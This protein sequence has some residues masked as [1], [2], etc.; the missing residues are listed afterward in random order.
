MS[1]K[2]IAVLAACAAVVGLAAYWAVRPKKASVATGG[3]DVSRTAEA[4]PPD[5]LQQRVDE[6]VGR[7][8][9]TIVL[10]EDDD[11]QPD[12]EKE[13]TSL[14]GRIIFQENH[15]AISTLSDELT[16]AIQNGGDW[17]RAPANVA[18]FLDLVEG[19]ADLHDA[20]KLAFRE[21]FTDF[22]EA[23]AGVKTTAAAKI[24][25]E[26]RV[27]TDRQALSEIQAMYEKELDKIFGRFE[28]RGMVVRREAW[29]RYVAY[30]HTKFRRE[31]ILK[32]YESTVKR[33]RMSAKAGHQD[34]DLES[35]GDKLPPKTLLL[36]FDDGPH[37]RYTDR[38]LE[39]LRQHQ[40]KSV[41]FELGTN[42]ARV[43]Q[44]RIQPT[45]AAAAARHLVEAGYTVGSHGFSHQVLP[46][47][48]DR[49][50]SD[51]ID[52]TN[53]LL[54]TVV[55]VQT[56]LFRP[57]Y[58]ERDTKVLAAIEAHKMRSILWNIDSRDWADPV[59]KSVANRVV[60]GARKADHGII[61]LH[62]IHERT[63]DALPLII[64]TLSADGYRFLAWDGQTFVPQ[65]TAPPMTTSATPQTAPPLYHESWAVV[66]AVDNYPK[67][68]K[69]QYAV[70]D[71]TGVRD[72]LLNKF[73]FKRDHVITLFNEEATREKILSALGDT[74]SNPNS[75]Q[76]DDRVFVFFAGHGA[77]RRLPSGRDLGYIIPWDA[78][79]Q[80]FQGQAISMTNFQDISESIPAKHVFFVMDS[81]YSGLALTR[82][83][84]GNYLREM[85]RRTARQM[86]TAGGAD[87]QVADN[88]PNGH[89]VFTWTLL[90]GLEGRADLN[91]DGFITAAELAAYVAPGV[92]GLSHQT[93]AFGNLVGSEGG[94]FVFELHPETE[95]LSQL[96]AQLDQEAIQL[97]ARLDQIRKDIAAK[98]A[99]NAELKRQI[100]AAQSQ[101]PPPALPSGPALVAPRVKDSAAA[102]LNRGDALFKEKRYQEALDEFLAA[103]KLD[104][105][106]AL[107][108]NN[109]G[110]I[111][112]RLQRSEESI[113]WTKK[114]IE[115]DPKRSV[116]YQNL[117]DL[118]YELNRPD[119]ARPYYEKYL[120][121]ASERPYAAVVRSR[122]AKP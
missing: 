90:Q 82:G 43:N 83:E 93:P 110:F 29:E 75:V 120:E 91:S 98:T 22:G 12:A 17:S 52:Q 113:Q 27:A 79:T 14:V 28:T 8:R 15:Q 25:L 70:N 112:S 121:L 53:R 77:T 57:P 71:A 72:L 67:W 68:P 41:F 26:Q 115:I 20:D 46:K 16:A 96:S 2:N 104:P 58:G 7:Y 114:A 30:L 103:A 117:G 106:N 108:A 31:E 107:A 47:M 99:R 102:H 86:L 87:E 78:D 122:L 36:T 40:I 35:Y 1:N 80:N 65:T 84:N 51:E 33:I 109:A 95:A 34:N 89:S 62:D 63:I 10:L 37:P 9:Q 56:P 59:A 92:S 42:L 4:P 49:E 23:L 38:V 18:R 61:L 45:R 24:E 44:D 6:I 54:K 119:D 55:N 11:S 13:T 50:I 105:K 97:N 100:A 118:Y 81:C 19:Q 76:R 94:E 60:A 73:G 66:I 85:S 3:G 74:L 101:P 64:D 39:I 5:P 88:G 116:A 21:M 32:T 69:L 111:Y 48:S